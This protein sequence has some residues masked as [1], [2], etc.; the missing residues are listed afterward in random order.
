M[1]AQPVYLAS[2]PHYEILD[3]LRGG[4]D[5]RHGM[6]IHPASPAAEMGRAPLAH[7]QV[8]QASEN[9]AVTSFPYIAKGFG[10]FVRRIS[11]CA[12]N[13]PSPNSRDVACR[14][15]ASKRAE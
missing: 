9:P 10:A 12:H 5:G 2:K 11:A 3:G 15:S 4:L 14:V 13:L 1:N 7:R 8:P 6:G